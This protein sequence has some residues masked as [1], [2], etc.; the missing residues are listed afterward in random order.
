MC[1]DRGLRLGLRF[2][3]WPAGVLMS[4]TA[5]AALACSTIVL[6]LPDRP[7]VAYSFDFAATG[8]GFLFVNPDGA[9]RRSVMEGTPA[10]WTARYGSVTFNQIGPGMPAAGMNTAGLVVSLMWNGKAVYNRTGTAPVVNELEF[11]QRLLDTSGSVDDA[12]ASLQDVR[13]HGMVPIHF[14]LADRFGRTAIVTPTSTELLIHT[15]EDMPIRALTN[16]SYAVVIE[17]IGGF[18]GFGGK[19]AIPS[20]DRVK[21]PNSLERF[22]MAATAATRTDAPTTTDRA[23]DALSDVATRETRWQ[24]V[25]DPS[26]QQIAFKIVGQDV[27]HIVELPNI[28]FECFDRPFFADLN[29]VPPMGFPAVLAPIE[30]DKVRET[31]REILASFSE[32]SGLGP[33][34]A[35]GLTSG[36]LGA[37]TCAP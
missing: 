26:Q 21:D 3:R 11:I 22:V 1:F 7:I 23:F 14:L 35:D 18:K 33:E 31:A 32:G 16:T 13:I 20:G 17:E 12:L 9:T 29:E 19:K 10:L 36:L 15:Q 37:V 27:L 25:F 4:L 28:D 5:S 6:G 34:M 30:P 2:L 8:S 24:I